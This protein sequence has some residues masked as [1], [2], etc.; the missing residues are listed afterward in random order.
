ML[1]PHAHSV[2]QTWFYHSKGLQLFQSASSPLDTMDATI[3]SFHQGPL[4]R[5]ALAPE[6]SKNISSTY[7]LE[8]A[9][10]PDAYQQQVTKMM[11]NYQSVLQSHEG[12]APM[13]LR[14]DE[15]LRNALNTATQNFGNNIYDEPTSEELKEFDKTSEILR[16]LQFDW[17]FRG[18]RKGHS[19]WPLLA[20]ARHQG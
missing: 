1:L 4:P 16:Q 3:S 15:E 14:I 5:V 6:E 12:P 18:R 9:T 2:T 11:G 7:Q 20:Y 19:S 17:I 10:A 8:T 13:G